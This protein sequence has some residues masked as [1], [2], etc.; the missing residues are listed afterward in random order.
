MLL[1]P[2][3]SEDRAIVYG[4]VGTGFAYVGYA[5]QFRQH[6]CKTNGLIYRWM[7]HSTLREK[8]DLPDAHRL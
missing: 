1:R 5:K 2:L 8:P 4:W 6:Q 3:E 7:E